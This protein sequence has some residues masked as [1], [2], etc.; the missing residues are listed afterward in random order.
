MHFFHSTD[1][2]LRV[3]GNNPTNVCEKCAG[4]TLETR[5][6]CN[7]PFGGFSGAIQC[8]ASGTGNVAFVRNTTVSEYAKQPNATLTEDV[9]VFVR[10]TDFYK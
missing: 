4:L 10:I 1:D 9:R 5:C 6:T 8:L 7:D 2:V 3:T